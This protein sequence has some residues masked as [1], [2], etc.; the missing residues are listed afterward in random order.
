MTR[1]ALRTATTSYQ[2]RLAPGGGWA[3][4]TYWGPAVEETLAPGPLEYDEPPSHLPS[5]EVAACEYAPYGVRHFGQLDLVAER[6]PVS[7]GGG[8]DAV[9][10]TV[11]RYTGDERDDAGGTT[12][13]RLHFADDLQR[14][15]ATLCYRV[16]TGHDVV[17]RWAEIGNAGDTPL[18]LER[19][20]SAAFTVPTPAGARLGHLHG[21]WAQEFRPAETEL[22]QGRLTL[23]SRFGITGLAASPWLSV[24]ALDEPDGPTWS[25]ALAWSGSWTIDADVDAA[26]GLTRVS[27]GR[28]PSEAAIELAP[29]ATFTTPVACGLY[30]GEGPQGAARA[31]HTYQR[32]LRRPVRPPIVYNS[33]FATGFDVR[34]GHQLELARTAAAIGVETFVVD[35]GWFTGRDDDRGG[36]GDW[37]PDP[38]KFPG[39]FGAF[40]SEVRALG[41]G[42]GLW[43]EPEAVSPRSRLYAEHPDWVYQVPG[44]PMTTIR[45]QYVLDLGHDD[46]AAWAYATLDG[47][48]AR[49][50]ISYLK[51]DMNR[52]MTERGAGDDRDGRHVANYYAILDRLRRDHPGVFLE[53]CAAGGGRADLATAARHDVLWPS[54]NTG[55]LDRLAVQHGFLHAFAPHLMSSWVTDDDGIFDTAPRSTTF[56]YL[57]AMSGVLGIGADIGRW[58]QAERDEAARWIGLYRSIR[59]VVRDGAVHQ[60]GHPHGPLYAVE[61]ALD[62]VVVLFTWRTGAARGSATHPSRPLRVRLRG[63][64]PGAAYRRRD[65]GARHSGAALASAGLAP[66]PGDGTDASVIV[67]ERV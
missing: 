66:L 57:T 15:T 12:E 46:A 62:D 6:P 45:N 63:A 34:A 32:G 29:G 22:R 13:L 61:Y 3:E 26:T 25:A 14:L 56:R 27:L 58:G 23:E 10:G 30:S 64:D 53:G 18:R 19:V 9:R 67:L 21:Q 16:Q 33:W 1:W 60:H 42:F 52:P 17:E 7:G 39:G 41:L 4:P 47:L 59:D 38:A 49:H 11:W 37:E 44:R 28:L 24:R 43:V 31:W 35:D 8:P 20:R 36:L 54:D 51:W 48:L 5:A 55:P 40:V 50:D 2:L 65:D